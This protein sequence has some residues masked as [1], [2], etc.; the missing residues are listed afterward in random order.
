[1]WISRSACRLR[2]AI[3][4][5][6]LGVRDQRTQR[7]ATVRTHRGRRA[8]RYLLADG[9]HLQDDVDAPHRI[10]MS[11]RDRAV[12]VTLADLPLLDLLAW[13]GAASPTRRRS[14]SPG[15]AV[16]HHR[17][18]RRPDRPGV[19]RRRTH[20]GPDGHRVGQPSAPTGGTSPATAADGGV[21]L[22]DALI[23]GGADPELLVERAARADRR[24][25]LRVPRPQR[26][27]LHLPARCVPRRSAAGSPSSPPTSSTRPE[28]GSRPG[29]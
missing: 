23:A 11:G 9:D 29:R 3:A 12:R 26:D 16:R 28:P 2:R 24:R 10:T 21:D 15:G 19:G 13:V 1:M 5:P 7:P 18:R 22:A 4:A 8:T 6:N 14:S 27:V 25:A 20:A 17:A